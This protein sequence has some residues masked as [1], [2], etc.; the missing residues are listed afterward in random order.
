MVTASKKRER[1]RERERESELSSSTFETEA[2]CI[3]FRDIILVSSQGT[4][5]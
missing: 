3:V 5:P 2:S 1:E 4:S